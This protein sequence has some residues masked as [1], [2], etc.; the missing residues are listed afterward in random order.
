LIEHLWHG[1]STFSIWNIRRFALKRLPPKSFPVTIELE[2][3]S[4]SPEPRCHQSAAFDPI[5]ETLFIPGG[6]RNDDKGNHCYNDAWGLN[7]NEDKWFEYRANNK[8]LGV[9]SDSIV[10]FRPAN[11][12]FYYMVNV[13]L[14]SYDPV[15]GVFTNLGPVQAYSADGQRLKNFKLGQ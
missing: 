4:P 2:P 7:L 8:Y 11:R 1:G 15:S 3:G 5:N 10:F 13:G 12:L 9:F 14:T 6:F